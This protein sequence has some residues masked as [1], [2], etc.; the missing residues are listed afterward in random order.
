MLIIKYVIAQRFALGLIGQAWP[1]D[2]F[3]EYSGLEPLTSTLPFYSIN[4]AVFAPRWLYC[5]SQ[6]SIGFF[7]L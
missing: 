4:K 1:I 2:F 7:T 3:V 5:R 6:K